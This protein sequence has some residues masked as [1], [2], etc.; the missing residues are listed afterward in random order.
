MKVAEHIA[1]SLFV[2]FRFLVGKKEALIFLETSGQGVI[3]SFLALL[4]ALPL[5]ILIQWLQFLA[6][7]YEWVGFPHYIFLFLGYAVSWVFF[8]VSIFYAWSVI[9]PKASYRRFITLYNWARVYVLLLML[10]A[11]V[12]TGFGLIEGTAK[13]LVFWMSLA[14]VLAYKYFITRVSLEA[15]AFHAILFV[16]FDVLLVMLFDALMFN[17][18]GHA[19]SNPL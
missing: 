8:A 6:P 13:T 17:A 18:F 5:F 19:V 2:A 16:F 10:P 4:F 9:G 3:R 14:I 11:F 15:N 12:L 1:R 7:G